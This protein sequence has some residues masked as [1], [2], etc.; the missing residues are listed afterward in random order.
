LRIVTAKAHIDQTNGITASAFPLSILTDD[1]WPDIYVACD[2]TAASSITTI[3][4]GTF[5]DVAVVRQPRS[6]DDGPAGG[7]GSTSATMTATAGW[8]LFNEFSDDTS[9]LYRNMGDGTLTTRLS[10]G[11]RLEHA[12]I[13][14]GA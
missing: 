9:T 5:T 2:S 1:G 12:S 11:N 13:L 8:I 4:T 6:N 10:R 7:M 14:A 3:T